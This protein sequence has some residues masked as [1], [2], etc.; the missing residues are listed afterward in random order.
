MKQTNSVTIRQPTIVFFFLFLITQSSYLIGQENTND[1]TRFLKAVLLHVAI[2]TQNVGTD[3][4]AFEEFQ[5]DFKFGN[6]LF[7]SEFNSITEDSLTGTGRYRGLMINFVFRSRLFNKKAAFDR[8]FFTLA[9]EA[10][11]STTDM[12]RLIITDSSRLAYEFFSD[13]FRI[14]AG[15]RRILTK[16]D[17]R[18]KFYTGLELVNEF[19]ISALVLEKVFDN[20]YSNEESS[21]KLFAKKS[22][23]A[24]LNIP[25]GVSF[26]FSNKNNL[27]KKN[28]LFFH[29][30]VGAGTQNA[31]P[32]RVNGL[33]VGSRLGLSLG[34]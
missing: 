19:N 8:E 28:A 9:F 34:L 33:F 14:T 2:N 24:Y 12:Y 31:D 4:P 29:L 32:F 23:N 5:Q 20:S 13:V 22:Y 1:S 21:R 26:R 25:F 16:K 30:N 27:L 6:K 7:A 18:F 11:Q 10:G 3:F 15:Y 17:R